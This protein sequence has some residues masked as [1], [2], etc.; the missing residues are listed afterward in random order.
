MKMSV[1]KNMFVT[2][3]H[4]DTCGLISHCDTLIDIDHVLF[5]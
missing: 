4:T 2:N 3:H 1:G 5:S